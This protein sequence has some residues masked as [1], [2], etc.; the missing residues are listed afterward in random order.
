MKT[1]SLALMLLG[2]V[3]GDLHTGRQSPVV[4]Q[5]KKAKFDPLEGAILNATN[6][7]LQERAYF[8]VWLVQAFEQSHDARLRDWIEN[9]LVIAREL[10]PGWSKLAIQKNLVS[11]LAAID[12]A[13]AMEGLLS[14]DP[15]PA[16]ESGGRPED[17]R[18]YAAQTIFP[19]ALAKGV[20][21]QRILEAA[22]ALSANGDFPFQALGLVMAKMDA[23]AT[24]DD[25]TQ[26]ALQAASHF[27]KKF[28]AD[29]GLREYAAFVKLSWE[30]LS[31]GERLVVLEPMLS[32]LEEIAGNRED[33]T[34]NKAVLRS[35]DGPDSKAEAN[36]IVASLQTLGTQLDAKFRE[37]WLKVSEALAIADSKETSREEPLGYVAM[38]PGK[39]VSPREMQSATSKVMERGQLRWIERNLDAE[40]AL[41]FARLARIALPD[42]RY[43][44]ASLIR[45]KLPANSPEAAEL[46][47]ELN[48]IEKSE[49]APEVR[50]KVLH[51]KLRGDAACEEPGQ[52]SLAGSALDLANELFAI[53]YNAAAN[54]PAYDHL[55]YEESMSIV[56]HLAQC[57]PEK[58]LRLTG[59]LQ[60][61][62]L[63]AY[64]VVAVAGAGRR[65]Q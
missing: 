58:A 33:G 19:A 63:R 16:D 6:F 11:A 43:R 48:R 55:G 40:P 35:T 18:C 24:R 20:P 61:P 49:L 38:P 17:L 4:T 31:S 7:P 65:G 3:T 32:R 60:H 22:M 52:E 9:G 51:T 5:E 64:A 21:A 30:K 46:V 42:L 25:I 54:R 29:N 62:V 57:D 47:A 37:R 13:A 44:A 59:K 56:R 45:Q 53:S 1:V 15:S 50:L 27:R 28:R 8:Y 34:L 2:Q 10:P 36:R 12:A 23:V 26:M 39:E 14:L 41:L